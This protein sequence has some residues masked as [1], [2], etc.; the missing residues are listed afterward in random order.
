VVI[1]GK[2]GLPVAR[3]SKLPKESGK[4]VVSEAVEVLSVVL[5][6]T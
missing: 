1:A 5:L 4:I 2:E 3:I 6:K